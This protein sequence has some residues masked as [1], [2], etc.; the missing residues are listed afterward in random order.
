MAT[1][2]NVRPGP[3][4]Y[5]GANYDGIEWAVRVGLGEALTATA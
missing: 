3:L 2:L 4:E 1:V 5:N